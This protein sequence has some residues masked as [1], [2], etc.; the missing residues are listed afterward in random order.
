MSAI[1]RASH[2]SSLPHCGRHARLIGLIIVRAVIVRADHP[3]LQALATQWEP[4]LYAELGGTPF[5]PSFDPELRTPCVTDKSGQ[6]RCVPG[7]FLIGNWQ[8]NAKGLGAAI[9]A[10]PDIAS[11]GND[12]CWGVWTDDK[13][14]RRW[15]RQEPPHGFEPRQQLLAALGCVTMLTFYPGFAGRFHKFWEK[16]Y[17]PCKARCTQDKACGRTYCAREPENPAVTTRHYD[18]A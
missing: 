1:S 8:S 14:G 9:G 5:P 2:G 17:W 12:K 11:V 10:H 18:F 13:G 16:E 15:L 7:A 3:A 6:R 4:D